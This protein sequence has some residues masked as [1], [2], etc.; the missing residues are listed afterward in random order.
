MFDRLELT[1][2]A[3][4]PFVG[5]R[6]CK[7]KTCGRHL[8]VSI[9]SCL[10]LPQMQ[11]RSHVGGGSQIW[12]QLALAR[13]EQLSKFRSLSRST[14][15]P[16]PRCVVRAVHSVFELTQ[17]PRSKQPARML[18]TC[19]ARD[20][21]STRLRLKT[22]NPSRAYK[23]TLALVELTGTKCFRP[24]RLNVKPRLAPEA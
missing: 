24:P 5:P 17:A 12:V 23:F 8:A 7:L 22:T 1:A 15:P 10:L 3:R 4:K 2:N 11:S 21:N 19:E 20:W 13:P 18:E 9:C 6:G 14:T 16:W